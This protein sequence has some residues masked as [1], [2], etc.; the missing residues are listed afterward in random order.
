VNEGFEHEIAAY[1][2]PIPPVEGIKQV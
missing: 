1:D 2:F